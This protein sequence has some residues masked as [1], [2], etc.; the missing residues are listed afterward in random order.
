M[1]G[2]SAVVNV[3]LAAPPQIV[4]AG[5]GIHGRH[6]R[7]DQFVL[8]HLWALHLYDYHGRLVVDNEPFELRPGSV[9]L[10]PPGAVTDYYYGGESEHWYVHFPPLIRLMQGGWATFRAIGGRWLACRNVRC[11]LTVRAQ[12]PT[13][14]DGSV[15]PI[16]V[17]LHDICI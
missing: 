9:S 5:R 6:G 2:G 16:G 17:V 4:G 7:H 13:T 14:A 15:P 10:V 3:R 1:A 11:L 8:P 12:A